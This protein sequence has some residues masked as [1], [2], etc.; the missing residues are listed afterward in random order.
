MNLV[1]LKAVVLGDR[2]LALSFHQAMHN[3]FV[4]TMAYNVAEIPHYTHVIYAHVTM[5]E[6]Y[7]I[8]DVLVEQ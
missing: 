6:E 2:I 1:T 3:Y 5:A 7:L 4:N 8:L